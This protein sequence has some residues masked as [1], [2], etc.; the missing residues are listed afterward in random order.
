MS[1]VG[2]FRWSNYRQTQCLQQALGLTVFGVGYWVIATRPCIVTLMGLPR[3]RNVALDIKRT[4]R[5]VGGC[6]DDAALC[7][8]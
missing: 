4:A 5:L 1:P 2:H 3:K 8:G 7:V 6:C